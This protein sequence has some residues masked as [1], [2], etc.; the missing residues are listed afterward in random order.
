MTE[1]GPPAG[2]GAGGPRPPQPASGP[3]QPRP[4][5]PGQP[6]APQGPPPGPGRPPGQQGPATGQAGRPPAAA[7][8]PAAPGQTFAERVEKLRNYTARTCRQVGLHAAAAELPTGSATSRVLVVGDADAGKSRFVAALIG[9]PGL[10]PVDVPHCQLTVRFGEPGARVGRPDGSVFVAGLA[11]VVPLATT[12]MP[13]RPTTLDVSLRSRVLP[14]LEIVDLPGV[15]GIAGSQ[16]ETARMMAELADAVF[17]VHDANGPLR[18]GELDFLTA[19]ADK[20]AC[21]AV[22]FSKTDIAPEHIVVMEHARRLLAKNPVTRTVPVFDTSA[23][24][25]ERSKQQAAIGGRL[26]EPLRRFAGLDPIRE[27]LARRVAGRGENLRLA[28]AARECGGL[29]RRCADLVERDARLGDE[30]EIQRSDKALADL[31]AGEASIRAQLRR[32]VQELRTGPRAQL[33][34]AI[35]DLREEL[36]SFTDGCPR[37]QLDTVPERLT[38]KLVVVTAT[39]WTIQTDAA[40]AATDVLTE[41]LRGVDEIAQMREALAQTDLSETVAASVGAGVGSPSATYQRSLRANSRATMTRT[42]LLLVPGV[43]A[44]M[45]GPIGW[46]I[47]IGL[48]AAGG[49]IGALLWGQGRATDAQYRQHIRQ[50]VDQTLNEAQRGLL[51]SLETRSQYITQYLEA[52]V[53]EL[54]ATARAEREHVKAYALTLKSDPELVRQRERAATLRKESAAAAGLADQIA[55]AAP[56]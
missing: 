25:Y 39:V 35:R 48:A 55:G 50:W 4:A 34:T 46:P 16:G 8:K 19:V 36:R 10:L 53:L 41:R 24:N 40:V 21:L 43:L 17:L 14:G 44:A 42:A 37:D 12:P 27:F 5:A 6:G 47:G 13:N 9:A 52:R 38:A 33:D 30:A 28:A 29:L 11:D 23:A 15:D 18:T 2:A 1:S 32:Q 31:I 51:T 49:G 26:V 7:G 22:V 20:V 3:G 56:A 45:S 54:L